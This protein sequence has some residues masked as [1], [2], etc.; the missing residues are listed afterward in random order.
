MAKRK[1]RA[2]SVE[3]FAEDLWDAIPGV[4]Q[5]PRAKVAVFMDVCRNGWKMKHCFNYYSDAVLWLA[6]DGRYLAIYLGIRGGIK[7]GRGP[8]DGYMRW[9]HT[10][11]VME[12]QRRRANEYGSCLA[13]DGVEDV[14]AIEFQ[15]TP[16]LLDGKR[17]VS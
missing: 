3:E 11:K 13:D 6:A 14:V 9:R 2:E 16:L 1:S 12:G 8:Q 10:K 7:R 4:K 17:D 5:S 15:E